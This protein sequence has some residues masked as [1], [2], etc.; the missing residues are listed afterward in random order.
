VVDPDGQG[1][2]LGRKLMEA[3]TDQ[4]DRDGRKCYLESSR[5]EPNVKIYERIGFKVMRRM[6]CEDAGEKCDLYCMVRDA[7]PHQRQ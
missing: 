7:N 1:R 2:G 3:V 6:T 5:K 4:A